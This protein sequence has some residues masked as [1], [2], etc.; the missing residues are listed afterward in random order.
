MFLSPISLSLPPF[1]KINKDI[2]GWGFLKIKKIKTIPQKRPRSDFLEINKDSVTELKS[3]HNFYLFKKTNS[4]NSCTHETTPP[5][6]QKTQ[7]QKVKKKIKGK[8][9]ETC[10]ETN[11]YKLR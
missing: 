9:I 5:K 3:Y 1:P 11:R 4:K 7:Q 6:K 2:V 8:I 10:S